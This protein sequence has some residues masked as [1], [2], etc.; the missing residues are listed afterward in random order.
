MKMDS[1][2]ADLYGE[3]EQQIGRTPLI[4]YV[5][6]VPNGNSILIKKECNNPF[7]SSLR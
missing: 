2:R 3:L 4:Q 1:K 7:G 5:G 6:A